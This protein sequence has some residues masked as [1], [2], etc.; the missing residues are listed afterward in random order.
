M[1][2]LAGCLYLII[3]LCIENCQRRAADEY[4]RRVVRR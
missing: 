1:L 3:Q 2:V 4:A